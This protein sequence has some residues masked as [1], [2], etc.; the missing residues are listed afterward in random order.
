MKAAK[1]PATGKGEVRS[2]LKTTDQVGCTECTKKPFT[3]LKGYGGNQ[4]A[5]RHLHN[6]GTPTPLPP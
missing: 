2:E 3:P 5:L 4:H 6:L 1:S